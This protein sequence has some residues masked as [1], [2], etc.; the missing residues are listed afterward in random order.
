MYSKYCNIDMKGGA[1]MAQVSIRIDDNI[2]EQTDAILTDLGLS[3][4]TAFNMFARQIIKQR[5]IPFPITMGTD[6]LAANDSLEEIR[7]RAILALQRAGQQS[8]ANGTDNM[9]M[10]E[11]DA[12]IAVTRAG[13]MAGR[14]SI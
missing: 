10:E 13:R 9:T 7:T 12:E 14:A 5:G 1:I 11:I 2:K 3:M 8:V 6:S 4:S